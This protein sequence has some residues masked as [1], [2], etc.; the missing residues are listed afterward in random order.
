MKNKMENANQKIM[1]FESKNQL[2]KLRKKIF[3]KK[4]GNDEKQ[5]ER[6]KKTK[7]KRPKNAKRCKI[8]NQKNAEQKKILIQI[9]IEEK[10]KQSQKQ[11]KK[12][13][14]EELIE[15]KKWKRRCKMAEK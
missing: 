13:W 3:M 2:Q 8:P 1:F 15:I 6:E 9:N 10:Q 7:E 11:K 14:T 4:H 5:N 12:K